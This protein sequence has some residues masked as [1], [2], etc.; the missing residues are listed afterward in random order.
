MFVFSNK[1]NHCFSF[2]VVEEACNNILP[3]VLCQYL[4]GLSEKAIMH[5]QGSIRIKYWFWWGTCKAVLLASGENRPHV[6]GS[7]CWTILYWELNLLCIFNVFSSTIS[8]VYMIDCW[9]LIYVIDW[10]YLDCNEI[11]FIAGKTNMVF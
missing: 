8:L 6:H 2:Q 3:S 4:Y 1:F 9:Y 11:M 7:K 10:W 5:P